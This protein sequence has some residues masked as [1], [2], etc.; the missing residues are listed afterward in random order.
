M[1][2]NKQGLLNDGKFDFLFMKQVPL[3][4]LKEFKDLASAE[5]GG[6]FGFTLKALMDQTIAIQNQMSIERVE[7]LEKK[8]VALEQMLSAKGDEKPIRKTVGGRELN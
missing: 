7:V 8:I 1:S 5:F 6:H 2:E 3:N 4:T